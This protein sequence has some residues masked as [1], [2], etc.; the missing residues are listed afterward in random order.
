MRIAQ[1]MN[2]YLALD[3]LT[4]TVCA[5]DCIAAN[6]SAAPVKLYISSLRQISFSAASRCKR[7]WG[8]PGH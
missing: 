3:A 6:K 8:R 2:D 1:R 7:F 5:L 4:W